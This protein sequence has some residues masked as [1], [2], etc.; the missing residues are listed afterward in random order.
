MIDHQ[1]SKTSTLQA[2][3]VSIQDR[4][5]L[6]DDFIVVNGYKVNRTS[7]KQ[8]FAEGGYRVQETPHFLLFTRKEAPSTILVH[9][10]A[11]ET[12]P[13]GIEQ[14]ITNELQPLGLLQHPDDQ[15]TLL[16]GLLDSFQ[17]EEIQMRERSVPVGELF[18]MNGN[19]LNQ[20][21]LKRR[22]L[23]SGYQVQETPHFFYCTREKAPATILVH[24]F[25]LGDLHTNISRHLVEEMR[26][27]G[28]IPNSVRLGE[29]MTGIV[30]TTFPENVRRAWNYFGANTLQ[31]LLQ[32]VS[33]AAPEILPDYGT[34]EASATLYQRVCEICVGER[35]LD[36]GCNNGFFALLLA[37]RRPFVKE[38]LGVDI[39]TEVFRVAQDLAITRNLPNVRYVQA[40]LLSD[41]CALGPFDTVTALHVLEHF[42]EADMY[43]V[44]RNLLQVTAQRLILAVPYEEELTTAYDHR[45]CFSRAKLEAVGAW[46]IEQLQGQGRTWCEDLC[47]GLLLIERHP[48]VAAR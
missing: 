23:Q 27:F 5:V 24:W 7:L 42:S 36:A 25:A 9:R 19:G 29:F 16:K 47:G 40:D 6:V 17:T 41:V 35:F 32:L 11:P 22:F 45:Q 2:R 3:K 18:V 15:K 1:P 44:L 20:R 33:T 31:R 30:G 8:R 46:C 26:P 12:M 34:L 39:D 10:F 48:L 38:V 21:A 28:C 37:E 43:E 13:S 14:C 4:S